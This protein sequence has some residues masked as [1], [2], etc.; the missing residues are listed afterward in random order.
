[1][2]MHSSV[3]S[4]C[5][6]L[7]LPSGLRYGHLYCRTWVVA[8]EQC[9][10]QVLLSASGPSRTTTSWCSCIDPEGDFC[11]LVI[12]VP[13]SFTLQYCAWVTQVWSL[14][15]LGS[16]PAELC[17]WLGSLYVLFLVRLGPACLVCSSHG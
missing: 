14:G 7:R 9:G 6:L 12:I 11:L 1:M 15:W 10:Q 16:P 4:S 2:Y 3:L 5:L 13:S 17:R 8:H